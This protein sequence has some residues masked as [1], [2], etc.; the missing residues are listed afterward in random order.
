MP[1][2]LS[3]TWT[4]ENPSTM[5]VDLDTRPAPEAVP[6]H[7]QNA[8]DAVLADPLKEVRVLK[9]RVEIGVYGA[10]VCLV[11]FYYF[12]LA[13]SGFQLLILYVISFLIAVTAIEGAFAQM[14]KLKKRSAFPVQLAVHVGGIQ[15]FNTAMENS[16]AAV[17]R[18]L[19]LRGAFLV[20][21]ADDGSLTLSALQGLSRT[22]AERYLLIGDAC[23]RHAVS[24]STPVCLHPDRD[25]L[26]EVIIPAGQQV[27]FVPL[28]STE[29]LIGVMG[30]LAG[31]SNKD[32]SD[33]QLLNI[34][35]L[36]LGVILENLRQK[37]ELRELAA[38]D[39]LTKVSNRRHFFD[40]LSRE[41]CSAARYDTPLAV[42]ML[43]FDGLKT[44]NDTFGHTAGDEALCALA[45]RLVRFSRASDLVARIGGDEF[46][47]ILP[48]TDAQGAQ[49][50]SH[51]LQ[52]AVEDESL[53]FG[54]GQR[55]A[56][57][58]SCGVAAFPDDAQDAETLLR[59]ADANMYGAKMARRRPV[60]R[61]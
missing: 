48:R 38:V 41:V 19:N 11:P 25:L 21:R 61:R 34:M 42:L 22:E 31:S 59:R 45:Q 15:L 51:R 44:I 18:L 24:A 7:R 56:I 46:A 5:S 16:L 9:R 57:A 3:E 49:D 17:V 23:V 53:P 28:R 4:R 50:L 54:E 43:D 60:R 10:L 20:L 39:E 29:R 30:L 55:I 26:A 52:R 13:F 37:E 8:A 33:F 58:I 14:F 27:V 47:V 12:V 6:P 40:Q 32:V 35:G 1:S 2:H 36:A